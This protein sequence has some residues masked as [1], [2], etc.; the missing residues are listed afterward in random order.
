MAIINTPTWQ[1]IRAHEGDDVRELALHHSTDLQVDMPTALQQIE[2]RQKAKDK[3][4]DLYIHEEILYPT[5]LSLEQCS[6]SLTA[7]YK[8]NILEGADADIADLSGGFGIDT[9]AFAR[10]FRH[11]HYIEP[12]V[13]LCELTQHN[14]SVLGLSN[15]E[16]HQGT[17]EEKLASLP[18]LDYI[19]IDPS[20]RDTHGNRVVSL[21][22]C[23]PNIV[24]WK[25]HL[26]EKARK[27]VVVKLSPMIDLK[28][29]IQQLP[30]V[31]GIH[32]VAVE[33][34]CKE[35]LFLLSSK[36]PFLDDIP[37]TAV[38][39]RNGDSMRFQ[40]SSLEEQN[41]VPTL[42]ND[43]GQYLYEPNAAI[44]KAGAFKCLA[45]RFGLNKLHPHS[46]L[47]TNNNFTENFPGRI[48]KISDVVPFNKKN[49]KKALSLQHANV[50][51][52]NFPISTDELKKAL[53]LRDGGSTYIFGTTLSGNKKA[54]IICE[55]A[56]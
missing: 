31:S 4:P 50:S 3:L 24:L 22:D 30:E 33:G 42:A 38:N 5:T 20:R 2:G 51:T 11:C 52:R 37:I 18:T 44:L 1:Y 41:A 17:M 34:E 49:I 54:L 10:K 29:T 56:D 7:E 35:V 16:I 28:R 9:F 12:Q 25:E 43:L 39:L 14:A 48:F 13:T 6:S 55:K 53:H 19:Y 26:L 23:T 36:R 47:Y 46:H 15:I 8:A 45:I 32:I 27:N 21:E 40:F